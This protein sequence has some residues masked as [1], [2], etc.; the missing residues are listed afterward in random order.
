MMDCWGET[1]VGNV[2]AHNE[3]SFDLIPELG[4]YMVADGAG[5]EAAGERASEIVVETLAAEVRST[6]G[7]PTLDC[8]VDAVDLANRRIRWEAEIDPT[9]GRMATTV[10]AAIVLPDGLG[11]VNVGDS[12]AYRYRMGTLECLTRDQSW[13]RFLA[14]DLS[15]SQA[16]IKR[17]PFRNSLFKAV[18]AEPAVKSDTVKAEFLDGDILLLCSDGL[19]K[20]LADEEIAGALASGATMRDTA[21]ALV[22]ATLARGAPDNVTVLL[23]QKGGTRSEG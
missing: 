5:G 22:E 1:H 11:I 15:L 2:R 8:V 21:Q 3:D 13:E 17:H 16:Q 4:I 12:R 19:H 9:L 18:G 14:E 7:S 23:V 6:A 10:T 20:V